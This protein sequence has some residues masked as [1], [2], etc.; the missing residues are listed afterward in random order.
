MSSRSRR[1]DAN[2]CLRWR[3]T[4]NRLAGNINSQDNLLNVLLTRSLPWEMTTPA[5]Q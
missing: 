4:R 3:G 2:K 1:R 5:A